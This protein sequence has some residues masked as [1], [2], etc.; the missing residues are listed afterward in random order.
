MQMH[1]VHLQS[2]VAHLRLTSALLVSWHPRA[3]AARA[4]S[5]L[6]ATLLNKSARRRRHPALSSSDH[7]FCVPRMLVVDRAVLSS[8]EGARARTM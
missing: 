8:A 4:A 2:T 1:R 7:V 6:L 5:R 3:Q